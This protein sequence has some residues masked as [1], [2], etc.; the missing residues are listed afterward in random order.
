MIGETMTIAVFTG[1]YLFGSRLERLSHIPRAPA[2]P[3][4]VPAFIDRST[5]SQLH[6][7]WAL[8]IFLPVCSLRHLVNSCK[9]Q[10][11]TQMR[12]YLRQNHK[13]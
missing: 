4:L 6:L 13:A 7:C 11:I 5:L 2:E 10:T 3:Q 12:P 8:L 9:I 1:Q